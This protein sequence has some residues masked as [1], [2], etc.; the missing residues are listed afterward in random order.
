M[1]KL[2]RSMNKSFFLILT[3]AG[4]TVCAAK[5]EAKMYPASQIPEKLK[6][7]A[8]AIIRYDKTE[9]KV[10]DFDKVAYKHKYAITILNEKG[11]R[12]ATF[13]EG[14]NFLTKINDI[15]GHLYDSS[16][17]EIRSLKEKDVADASTFG[18]TYA[19]HDDSRIK[20]YDF[21]YSKYPYTVEYEVDKTIKTTFFL[22]DWEAQPDN[23][24]AVE[25]SDFSLTYPAAIP[26]RY[27]DY[28]MPA[29]V[30]RSTSKDGDGNDI[31]QWKLKNIYAYKEEPN[32]KT[33][34]HTSPTIVLSP[35][36]FELLKYKGNMQSWKDLGL[37]IYRLNEGRDVLPEDKKAVVKSLIANETDTYNKIQKLY[38][39]MQQ[40]TR[41]VAN[42]YGIAGWQT[43]DAMNVAN[44][45]YGD[46]KGLTNYLKALLKEAG[47]KS[48]TTLVFA[49]ED[50]YYKLDENFPANNFNHVI[51]C[52][53]QAT[54]T[55][56]VECTS[57]LLPAG[58][59]GSFT[60]GRKVLLTSEE[61]GFLCST[62]SYDKTKNTI[63]RRSVM[64]LDNN[65]R[66]QKIKVEN[67]YSGL[68][69][70]EM[71]QRLKTLPENKI[72]DMVNSI[73]PFPSYNVTDYKYTYT[74]THTLPAI[75][76]DAELV[77]SGIT[78]GT[79]KRT[80]VNVGWMRNPM[81]EIFQTETRTLP[82]VL[83]MSF[84]IVDTVLVQLPA[85]VE[86]ES[87]PEAVNLKYPFAEYRVSFE[88]KDNSLSMIR[89]YEQNQGVY[90]VADYENYQ[91]VYKTINSAKNNLNVV[92]LNKAL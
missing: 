92:L 32:S 16:G 11:E 5:D 39:Y 15:K 90:S 4:A 48:Y 89:V 2:I 14:Y 8:N 69:Q 18:H 61:G 67:R 28:Q 21:N 59:V 68:L 66:Q 88:K 80:F 58:Y 47:I 57:Q 35:S 13:S 29:T 34:N 73:F 63:I 70:D 65:S 41:Y 83:D 62:P 53:P 30:E 33:G 81:Q 31:L 54:D 82:F 74:G 87:I 72:R 55:I 50:D 84:K 91:K 3:I 25:Q 76:E 75:R 52:V 45:G 22:P 10:L 42:E 77:V 38:A 17:K 86:I 24:C 36:Q 20:H 9:V 12:Y 26:V 1:M 46:C 7:N 78:N 60:Q 44:N 19:F 43:F 85:G 27:K 49:G 51:L 40:T 23:N 37:F 56:W 64:A 71:E 6:A 79:Q